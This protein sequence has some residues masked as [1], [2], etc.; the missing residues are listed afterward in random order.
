MARG[1]PHPFQNAQYPPPPFG[2][3]APKEEKREGGEGGWGGV[4]WRS[5]YGSILVKVVIT[6]I[7]RLDVNK[8]I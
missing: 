1:P 8:A 4:G 2:M 7:N 6:E 3:G 5:K